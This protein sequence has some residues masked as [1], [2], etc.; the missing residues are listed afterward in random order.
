M[1]NFVTFT[2]AAGVALTSASLVQAAGPSRTTVKAD[3]ATT[4]VPSS[5]GSN[6][7][8]FDRASFNRELT[9]LSDLLQP[10]IGLDSLLEDGVAVGKK[11]GTV[12]SF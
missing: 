1:K 11:S 8:T 3:R 10:T 9:R 6:A 2:L 4:V 5:I 7:A 12:W